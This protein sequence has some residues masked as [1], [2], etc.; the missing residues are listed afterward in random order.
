MAHRS[1]IDPLEP[2]RHLSGTTVA[3]K[4]LRGTLSLPPAI[5]AT[6]STNA[7][8]SKVDD[9]SSIIYDAV[10]DENV[11]GGAAGVIQDGELVALGDAGKRVR[12]KSSNTGSSD[13]FHLGSSGK[14][15]TSTMVG[16]LIELKK[17]DWNTTV[18]KV[19]PELKG[20]ITKSF[21]GVTVWQLMTNRSGLADDLSAKTLVKL[22]TLKG[23]RQKQRAAMVP[24]VLAG[25]ANGKPGEKFAYSNFGYA[26]LGAMAERATGKSFENLMRD[27]V[28]NPLGMKSAG[29]GA[30][31]KDAKLDQPRG[32][33]A[34]GKA[35]TSGND[36]KL[37][38]LAP[39][40]TMSMSAGDW[41]KFL[42]IHMGVR[43]NGTKLIS[44]STLDRL[45]TPYDGS[46]TS[47]AAGWV[48]T[49]VLGVSVLSHDGTNDNWYST[50]QLIPDL[51]YA[52]FDVVNQGGS[53]GMAAAYA[54][55]SELLREY[56]FL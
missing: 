1:F 42:R 36:D 39:A 20:K 7:V 28:F 13:R 4:A 31:G 27:Y 29:F 5:E 26:V 47:Y 46:G 24:I 53:A 21:E 37:P 8:K 3:T 35:R 23:D 34:S 16:R 25:G 15:M 55:K 2:R 38:Y 51:K 30:Q 11:P 49:K 45:H 6:F 52:A 40:G 17:L 56:S 41:S 33:D 10:H 50:V 43:V 18:T 54:I 14:A 9:L 22:G 44:E 19:F 32:H 48:V 12:G